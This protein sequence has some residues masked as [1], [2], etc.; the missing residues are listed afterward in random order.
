VSRERTQANM[1]KVALYL[2]E[3]PTATQR[4]ISEGTSLSEDQVKH[5]LEDLRED[6]HIT[7][8]YN[9]DVRYLGY[10]LRYRVDIFVTP[11]KLRGGKGGLLEHSNVGSQE[12]LAKY[13]LRTLPAQAQFT[14]KILVEDVRILLGHPADLSASVYATDT[15]AMLE[16][17]TKGL[18]MCNA[19]YQ[20]TTCLEAWSCR[21]GYA[22]GEWPGS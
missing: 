17:V 1:K 22:S 15:T 20:T 4:Q 8:R 16:F 6:N 14:N 5:S 13:I 9:V 18:R 7:S 21:R 11:G 2:H 19:V 10:T 3:H 12:E